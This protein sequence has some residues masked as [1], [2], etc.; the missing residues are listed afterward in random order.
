MIPIKGKLSSMNNQMETATDDFI[1]HGILYND[2]IVL[3]MQPIS[4]PS[5]NELSGDD[6]SM[7]D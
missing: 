3:S 7:Q 4:A 6:N 2:D 5:G 1:E